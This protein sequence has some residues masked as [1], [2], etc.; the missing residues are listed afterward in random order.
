LYQAPNVNDEFFLCNIFLVY[1]AGPRSQPSLCQENTHQP[2]HAGTPVLEFMGTL[3]PNIRQMHDA[4]AEEW[5]TAGGSATMEVVKLLCDVSLDR[6]AED[7]ISALALQD[8]PGFDRAELSSAF[9]RFK[10]RLCFEVG[11][12]SD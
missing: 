5:L 10:C 2:L 9:L 12:A 7:A 6:L 4:I 1:D 3:H 8:L 11:N